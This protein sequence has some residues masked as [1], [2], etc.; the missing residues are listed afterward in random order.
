MKIHV[1][2]RRTAHVGAGTDNRVARSKT[3]LPST[4]EQILLRLGV[5][6]NFA[7]AV[8]GDL[9]E[10]YALRVVR[11]GT[12]AARG[13]YLRELFRCTPHFIRSWFRHTRRFE[14][15]RLAAVLSVFVVASAVIVISLTTRNGPPARLEGIP[16]AIIVNNSEPVQLQVHVLDA[17]GHVLRDSRVR[18]QRE[19][20]AQLRV[21]AA[22]E[23]TCSERGDALI[24]ATFGALRRSFLLQCRP[25]D[26]FAKN[27]TGQPLLLVGGSDQPLQVRALRVDGTPETSLAGTAIVRD[28]D[29]A[30]LRGL[31]V[32]PKAPG[33]TSIDVWVGGIVDVIPITVLKRIDDAKA[34][35]PFE[36]FAPSLR[37]ASGQTGEW[38]IPAGNYFIAFRSDTI[39]SQAL[40]FSTVG[41]TCSRFG[42]AY[43]YFCRAS[44]DAKLVV[45]APGR[46]SPGREFRGYLGV[47]R[48][49]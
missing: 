14:P 46:A 5:D 39:A 15:M 17:A 11:D 33:A 2:P 47:Q 8:L 45:R 31:S 38:Q 28:S 26:H 19:S 48:R 7:G 29:I 4:G 1:T 13:W 43:N 32:H 34:L 21:S 42:D 37:L 24:H 23:V 16:D 10:E 41:A 36:Y 30:S 18:Y 44:S 6:P 40:A 27:W 12:G 35:R 3:A 20:G 49:S 9:A 25:I 22:G